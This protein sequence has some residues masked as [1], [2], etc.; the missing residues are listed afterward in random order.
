MFAT[1][2]VMDEWMIFPT[3]VRVEIPARLSSVARDDPAFATL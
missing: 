1:G 3:G 2:R